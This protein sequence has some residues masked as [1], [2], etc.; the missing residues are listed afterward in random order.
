MNTAALREQIPCPSTRNQTGQLTRSWKP[1]AAPA[2]GH[3][4]PDVDAKGVMTRFVSAY[5]DE[6]PDL[7]DAANEVAR[8][9]GIESR[10]NRC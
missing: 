9:A 8:E 10:S 1:T 3:Q 2:S 4:L 6:V 5:I 7:L